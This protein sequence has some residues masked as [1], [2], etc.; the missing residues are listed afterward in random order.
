MQYFFKKSIS[1]TPIV[2]PVAPVFRVADLLTGHIEKVAA[3]EQQEIDQ[4]EENAAFYIPGPEH[5]LQQANAARD[6]AQIFCL[7][8]NQEEEQEL[9]IRIQHG[10]GKEQRCV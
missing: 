10:K 2:A 7:D 8:R 1:S 6:H 3:E 4:G 9:H 5:K